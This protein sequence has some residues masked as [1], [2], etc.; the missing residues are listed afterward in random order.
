MDG[1]YRDRGSDVKP[2]VGI[3]GVISRALQTGVSIFLCSPLG[4]KLDVFA[5][6][7][8]LSLR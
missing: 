2:L 7:S 6:F 3:C 1:W 5:S 8:G 4:L